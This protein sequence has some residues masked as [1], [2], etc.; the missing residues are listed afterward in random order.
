MYKIIKGDALEEL[1]KLP[2][3][4]VDCVVTSP[5]YWGHRDYGVD[6]QL[7]NE[8]TQWLYLEKLLRI[9][10]EVQRVLK[11]TGTCWVNLGDTY[12]PKTKT[13]LQIPSRFA[14]EMV[15]QGWILR[16]EIIWHKP[17]AMP[18]SA[19]DRF[20]NDFEKIYF[21][22]KSPKYYFEKQL[23]PYTKPMNR[24]GGTKL[25]ATPQ[26]S[27]WDKNT[28]HG[29][30]RHRN[31]RPNE[32]GKNKRTVWSINTK[33][34]KHAHFAVFPEALVETPIKAGSPKGGV[35]LD[36][37]MGSGTTL[38]V[39]SR[40]GRD[41]IGIELNEAYIAIAEERLKES[42]QKELGMG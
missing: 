3:E 17:N 32:A 33:P 4:S 10:R 18:Q 23:E 26:G 9:F 41:S 31:M 27:D 24:W 13:L 19:T 20:T 21:F 42:P 12:D 6:G 22:T 14:M 35:V 39:A 16:N 29:I 7:G 5:P 8:V 11:P 40:E 1:K 37:F 34:F 15:H 38:A 36:P 28:G 30:Y 2:S 25:K